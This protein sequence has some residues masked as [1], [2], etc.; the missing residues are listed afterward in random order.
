MDVCRG[1]FSPLYF[2]NETVRCGE[3]MASAAS[4]FSF[5]RK[6]EADRRLGY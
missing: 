5:Q 3:G 6:R 1:V 4:Q 2:D